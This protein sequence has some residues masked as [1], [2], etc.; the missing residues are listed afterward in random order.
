[1][2]TFAKRLIRT[3]KEKGYT[4]EQLAE[5]SKVSVSSIRR[6]EQGA[7]QNKEPSAY[8]LLAISQVLD[9]TPEYLLLGENKM[10]TYT[11]AIK[12][13]LSQITSFSIIK[14]I[15]NIELNETVLSH[16]ELG[17]TLVNEVRNA[18]LQNK[19][20]TIGNN[21]DHY[22]TKNYVREIIIRYCQNRT[23]LKKEY[24]IAD[25]MQM[26]RDEKN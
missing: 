21:E 7:K 13:E 8:N 9:V 19:L 22:C 2:E 4:Q 14:S 24:N 5:F 15:K 6:Y 12:K 18:W 26:L 20:F 3:R 23:S 25:G 11:T 10:N 17:E 1:M 16:L